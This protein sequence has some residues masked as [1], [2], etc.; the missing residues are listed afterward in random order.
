MFIGM[1]FGSA[2]TVTKDTVT[3]YGWNSCGGWFKTGGSFMNYC[4]FCHGHGTL[5][6]NPK[7]TYE[8]EFT[9]MRCDSDFCLCGR[10]KA[11]HSGVYLTRVVVKKESSVDTNMFTHTIIPINKMDGNY[12]NKLRNTLNKD[13]F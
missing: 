6:Y 2:A 13:L 11:G 8:G 5:S 7:G 12:I 3:A 4:P 10:C 9:C 1:P